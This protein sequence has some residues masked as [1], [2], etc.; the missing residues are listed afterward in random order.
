MLADAPCGGS[1]IIVHRG[2]R[3]ARRGSRT[4]GGRGQGGRT[5]N[6][7]LVTGA[8]ARA[9][10]LTLDWRHWLGGG[11][12]L[13]ALFVASRSASISSRSVGRGGPASVAAGHRARGPARR[14][15]ARAGARAGAPQRDG[16]A[17]RR[18]AGA[19]AAPRQPRRPAR[20][21]AGSSR[22][23]CQAL[24]AGAARAAVA[25]NPTSM[26]ARNLTLSS[27][28]RCSTSS[29]ASRCAHRPAQR[30][31]ALLLA[32]P[33][34]AGRFMPSLPPILDGWFSSELRLSHRSLHR[35]ALVP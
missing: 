25:P 21:D 5:L 14:D 33:P 29:R 35:P 9:R 10:T 4:A 15:G 27:S 23:S 20:Q 3:G 24:Q 1:W 7:I 2:P 17:P 30:L 28:P 13:F 6:I 31:E 16:G 26:P 12:C 34:R 8:H 32:E 18:A 22:R 19:D 11:F